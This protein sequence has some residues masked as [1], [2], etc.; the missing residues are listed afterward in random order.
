MV[1]SI[2]SLINAVRRGNVPDVGKEA[3]KISESAYER[4]LIER[5]FKECGGEE[6]SGF[7]HCI[8]EFIE[9]RKASLPH[10]KE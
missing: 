5:A 9:E 4:E 2:E 1:K 6:G 8:S 7:W 10:P 3:R